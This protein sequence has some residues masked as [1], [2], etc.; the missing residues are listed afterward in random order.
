[1]S[2]GLV[3]RLYRS[4]PMDAKHTGLLSKPPRR[5]LRKVGPVL[6]DIPRGV[7]T[8]TVHKNSDVI[9]LQIGRSTSVRSD[10]FEAHGLL[11]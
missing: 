10:G 2:D 8:S 9:G 7:G 3:S 5:L 4:Q 1:M 6:V 11:V